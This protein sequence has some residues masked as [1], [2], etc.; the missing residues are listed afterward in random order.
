[1]SE[2]KKVLNDEELEN[3]NGGIVIETI[4][5]GLGANSVSTVSGCD[6]EFNQ[7]EM[8]GSSVHIHISEI[9]KTDAE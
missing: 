7:K 4:K 3:A 9:Q 2:E 6:F 1:M 5:G 8:M